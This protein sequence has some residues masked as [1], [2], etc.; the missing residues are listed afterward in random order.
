MDISRMSQVII[1]RG[2]RCIDFYYD[3]EL[4]REDIEKFVE[5]DYSK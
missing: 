2:G 1:C 5:S 4:P 3:Q